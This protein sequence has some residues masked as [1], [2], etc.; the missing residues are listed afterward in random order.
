MRR[1]FCWL[2]SRHPMVKVGESPQFVLVQTIC[3]SSDGSPP[4]TKDVVWGH[5][6]FQ[7]C[8]RCGWEDYQRVQDRIEAPSS[9][10]AG[11]SVAAGE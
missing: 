6:E 10:S 5:L 2:F 3:T 7:K 4:T 8:R 9:R 1:L 11:A